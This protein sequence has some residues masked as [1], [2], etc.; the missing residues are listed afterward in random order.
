MP[1][2]NRPKSPSIE[3]WMVEVPL[4]ETIECKDGAALH[5]ALES[6]TGDLTLSSF[7][8]ACDRLSTFRSEPV[9]AQSHLV[10]NLRQN[11]GAFWRWLICSQ[12]P[13]DR[14]EGFFF[15]WVSGRTIRKIGQWPSLLDFAGKPDAPKKARK[16][17][18]L[19]KPKQKQKP[20]PKTKG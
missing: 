13:S 8:P 11:G 15:F 4:Y 14:H 12:H 16:R 19:P 7:C 1:A 6:L 3:E 9:R 2:T 20:K 17:K 18:S 5:H 10:T